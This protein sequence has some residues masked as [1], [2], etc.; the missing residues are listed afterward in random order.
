L[1]L[2][3]ADTYQ[4]IPFAGNYR[5]S[6]SSSLNTNAN[7]VTAVNGKSGCSGIA[8]IGGQGTYYAQVIYAAQAA[9]VAQQA[10]YPGSQNAMIILGDGD[11]DA[12]ALNANTSAGGSSTSDGTG[13]VV[14]SGTT[15]LNGTGNSTTNPAGYRSY[16]YPSALGQCGQSVEAANNAATNVSYNN[17]GSFTRVYTVG[18][19]IAS[20]GCASDRTYSKTLTTGGASW[21]PGGSA[22]QSMKAMA[23]AAGYFY[24]DEKTGGTCPSPNELN[25]TQLKQIFQAIAGTLS[26]AH[27]VPNS[28]T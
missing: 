13:L 11:E 12:S 28:T 10:A 17:T 1:L 24:S 20:G 7:I 26:G 22:C 8:A 21:S 19:G 18:Y 2:P 15:L 25:F 6:D 16:A 3:S 23:S 9:L 4:V 5:V 27:L 14:T